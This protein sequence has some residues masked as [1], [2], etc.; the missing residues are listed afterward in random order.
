MNFCSFSRGSADSICPY[1]RTPVPTYTIS[2]ASKG[3][4][5]PH[6]LAYS[7]FLPV[8]NKYCQSHRL[9]VNMMLS[10]IAFLMFFFAV[11]D[12]SPLTRWIDCSF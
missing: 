8:I 1:V 5:S 4:A 7:S 11:F 9:N 10:N 6:T 2:G 3:G 12:P